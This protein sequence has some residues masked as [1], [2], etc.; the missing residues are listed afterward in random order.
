MKTKDLSEK[1]A[2][3]VLLTVSISLTIFTVGC[4]KSSNVFDANMVL[5]EEHPFRK[6]PDVNERIQIAIENYKNKKT[7]P[8]PILLSASLINHG[9][10]NDKE[11]FYIVLDVVDE[12]MDFYGFIIKDK[13]TD[14][15]GS[16]KILEEKY[17]AF[18]NYPFL[19][20]VTSCGFPISVRN[21]SQRKDEQSW[22]DYL[23]S[24]F[25]DFKNE[26]INY[27]ENARINPL[28]GR[29]ERD[30]ILTQWEELLPVI[31]LSMPNPN[32]T[33]QIQVFD[34]AGH[35]SNIVDLTIY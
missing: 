33:V 30:K 25:I 26:V 13:L 10:L 14:P 27:K 4:K 16:I 18:V 35:K 5:F 9:Q 31:W 17:P 34:K 15:N 2:F 19:Y 3:I 32:N 29:K 12:D 11:N 21:N 6:I 23:S 1:N 7:E 24:D 28:G 22:K 8:E 20:N